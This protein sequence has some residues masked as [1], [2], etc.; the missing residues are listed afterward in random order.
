V[1]TSLFQ[2]SYFDGSQWV[3]STEGT[4]VLYFVDNGDGTMD[5]MVRGVHRTRQCA[6]IWSPVLHSKLAAT[7]LTPPLFL[8]PPPAPAPQ[9]YTSHLSDFSG[10]QGSAGFI[11]VMVIDPIGDAGL[12]GKIFDLENLFTT[13]VVLSLLGSFVIAWI[14]SSRVDERRRCV[15]TRCEPAAAHGTLPALTRS[16]SHSPMVLLPGPPRPPALPRSPTPLGAARSC[17][18]CTTCTSC[19]S[20]SCARALVWICCT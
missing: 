20:E 2:C 17:K 3:W 11:T 4:I 16:R 18:R 6:R 19:C 5:G 8:P 12:L 10:Q 1:D 7:S 9:C 13:I 14:I 15:H